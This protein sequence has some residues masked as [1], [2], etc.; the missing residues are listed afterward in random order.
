[1]EQ[2]EKDQAELR[3]LESQQSV[4]NQNSM[5]SPGV[6]PIPQHAAEQ[7]L[8]SGI[9][10]GSVDNRESNYDLF[11]PLNWMLDGPRDFPYSYAAVRGLESIEESSTTHPTQQQSA[12]AHSQLAS[13]PSTK[14]AS[15][16][17]LPIPSTP[18]PASP[19]FN[20]QYQQGS[21]GI[22]N[23]ES[24][25][26]PQ[27]LKEHF[28]G[29]MQQPEQL[30]SPQNLPRG[31]EPRQQLSHQDSITTMNLVKPISI[32]NPNRNIDGRPRRE[33]LAGSH[34]QRMSWGGVSVGSWIR[35]E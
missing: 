32:N 8:N 6:G 34:V 1:M 13:N 25:N 12:N 30:Q 20:Q 24:Q 33:S 17:E 10:S 4:M 31:S 7:E 16:S 9:T 27:N 3:R 11:D 19:L 5:Q 35:D 18:I 26:M 15:T 14:N 2:Q 21:G 29:F 28:Q 22:L 23:L